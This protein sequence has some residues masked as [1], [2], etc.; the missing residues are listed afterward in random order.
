L[1]DSLLQFITKTSQE[2]NLYELFIK[3]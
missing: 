3:K 1:N 2:I